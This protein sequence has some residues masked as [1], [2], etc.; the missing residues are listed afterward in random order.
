[1]EWGRFYEILSRSEGDDMDYVA[2]F[3]VGQDAMSENSFWL[4]CQG[5]RFKNSYGHNILN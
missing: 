5:W 2:I 3:N 4:V 1:M